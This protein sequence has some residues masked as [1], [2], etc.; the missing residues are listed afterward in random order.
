MK[1]KDCSHAEMCKWIDEL[2][3]RGCDF[4]EP[5][6]LLI[7]K[8]D[9][10]LHQDDRKKWMDSIKR[11]KENGVIILPPYFTP[12][13]VPNDVEIRI[14]QPCEDAISREAV[15]KYITELLSGYLYDEE[16]ERLEK[17]NAYLWELP[18]VTPSRRKG[19]WI[20]L[21]YQRG[22]FE[23]SECHTQGYVDT[24]MYEPKWKYCPI[25]GAEMESEE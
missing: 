8:S 10:L 22:K 15:D 2:E 25:C 19:H 23:C 3:G 21:D 16:R 13:L 6:D 7:I 24:C 11:E 4:G 18:S 20:Q 9:I 14:E 17:L 5:C 1:C 12:L